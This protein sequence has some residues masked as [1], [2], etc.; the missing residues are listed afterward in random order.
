MVTRRMPNWLPWFHSNL[1]QLCLWKQWPYQ[2]T[3]FSW[4]FYLSIT[5]PFY[6]PRLSL[7]VIPRQRTVWTLSLPSPSSPIFST[8]YRNPTSKFTPCL[9][10]LTV[11]G[12]GRLNTSVIPASRSSGRTSCQCPIPRNHKRINLSFKTTIFNLISLVLL[13]SNARSALGRHCPHDGTYP[14]CTKTAEYLLLWYL[15]SEK[16]VRKTSLAVLKAG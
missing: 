1:Q 14:A 15:Q 9:T 6:I 5:P 16:V 3:S 2:K 10:Q 11:P 8:G 13:P 12:A 7:H 4:S